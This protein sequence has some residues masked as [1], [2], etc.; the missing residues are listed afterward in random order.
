MTTDS[1][2]QRAHDHLQFIRSTLESS[3]TFTAIPGYGGIGMGAIA[4]LAATISATPAL[5]AHTIHVWLVS[6]VAAVALGGVAMWTKARRTETHLWRGVGRRFLLNLCPALAA[7]G[8]LT[9]ALLQ[10]G[11]VDVIPGT[12][13]LLYGV[14]VTTAGAFSLWIVPLMGTSFMLLGLCALLAPASGNALLALGFGG[15]HL[16]FGAIIARRYGG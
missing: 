7:G 16:L 6:A 1:L 13:L 9:L 3:G 5:H 14:G 15:L 10:R 8:A 12:W 4:L 2:Q 11:A